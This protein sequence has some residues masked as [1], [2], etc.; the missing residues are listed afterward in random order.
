[1]AKVLY[2]LIHARFIISPAGLELMVCTHSSCPVLIAWQKKKFQNREYGACPRVFCN[3]QH[4]LPVGL[5]DVL[6]A[7]KVKLFCPHCEDI[8]NPK[9]HEHNQLDG[10]FFGSTFP[11][12]FLQHFPE[13]RPKMRN[14]QKYT[15]KIFGFRLAGPETREAFEKYRQ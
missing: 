13:L 3:K 2:G 14:P 6:G 7:A 15:P 4:L 11:H 12:I 8:Y 5:S 1:M 10:A 9:S